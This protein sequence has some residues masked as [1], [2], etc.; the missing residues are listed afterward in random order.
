MP[1]AAPSG[2]SIS[3]L[4]APSGGS[5]AASGQLTLP[6]PL[7][8]HQLIYFY[9]PDEWEEFI[10]EYAIGLS[11]SY[12]QIKRIGG[13]N[14]RGADIAA[15]LTPSGFDGVWDCLQCKHYESALL[16]SDAYPEMFKV[17]RAVV[18]RHYTLPR[19]Y[20]FMAPKACNPTLSRQLSSPSTLRQEFLKRFEGRKPLGGGLE[21]ELVTQ[22][23]RLA[24][25]IDYSIFQSVELHE[26]I[27]VHKRTRY[28]VQRFGA[29]LPDRPEAAPPP[30][31]LSTEER[32]YVEH[33][34]AA[35]EERYN[36]RMATPADVVQNAKVSKHFSRQREAFYSAEALRMFARDS[37]LPGTFEKLQDDVYDGVIETHF[38]DFDYGLDRL[39]AVLE[40]VVALNLSQKN[41]LYSVSF[42]RDKIGICHQLAN[43]DRLAWCEQ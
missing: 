25:T 12:H 31:D 30:S 39:T 2:Q 29:P 3:D 36:L 15:F 40:A 38:R 28:H 24:E 23:K 32:R 7:K 37:V 10:L 26:M 20:L 8:P 16:P 42:N 43:D 17:L 1:E 35:Y 4:P 6:K 5:P 18:E 33:L 21:P 9:S 13:S 27:E 22:I 34:L 41:P 14:D 11:T 19:R